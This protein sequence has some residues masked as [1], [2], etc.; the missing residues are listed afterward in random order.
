METPGVDDRLFQDALLSALSD[1]ARVGASAANLTRQ[2]RRKLKEYV[3]GISRQQRWLAFLLD[4]FLRRPG[5]IEHK[6]HQIL[7]VALYELVVL[8]RPAHATVD[9]AVKWTKRSVREAAGSLSNGVL[10]SVSRRLTALPTPNTGDPIEDVAIRYSHPTWMVRRWCVRWGLDDTV[11]FLKHN[12]SRPEHGIRVNTL[13]IAQRAFEKELTS[14]G[15]AWK[16]GVVLPEILRVQN[17]QPLLEAGFLS[18][19]LCAIQDEAAALVGLVLEA[20]AGEEVVDA[21]AGR[22][23]KAIHA[24]IQMGNAGR[25]VCVDTHRGRLTALEDAARRH[26]V[27]IIEVFHGDLRRFADAHDDLCADRVLVD[28]PCTG[29]GVLARRHDLR[30]NRSQDDLR[31]LV[32][33]QDALMEA[34]SRLV[35][36]GGLLVYSTCTV[37]PD[38][39]QERVDAFLA[40]HEN[41][42]IEPISGMPESL[43][44]D[45]GALF[46]LPHEHGIDGGF[47]VRLRKAA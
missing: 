35:R 39:N 36:P 19:G 34:A 16:P 10:R 40:S 18:D 21:C 28:A 37:E 6:L 7:L 1:E 30:W 3:A 42:R 15:I 14:M 47:V 27:D 43:R 45:R 9:E 12:N 20:G 8:E 11:R 46:S 32:R 38:E 44:T 22:G 23:G 26:G 17:V 33:L 29:F 31:T 41:F 13:K 2:Q 25:I 4:Q 5:R 24:A